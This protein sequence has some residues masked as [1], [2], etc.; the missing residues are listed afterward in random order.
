MSQEEV[1]NAIEQSEEVIDEAGEFISGCHEYQTR[2]ALV[3]PI[4]TSLGWDI[5]DVNQVEVEYDTDWGRVDYALLKNPDG[6]LAIAVEAKALWTNLAATSIQRQILSYAEGR[7]KGYLVLTD[8]ETWQIYDLG[9]RGRFQN[10]LVEHLS[11]GESSAASIAKTLNQALRRN[12]H[13]KS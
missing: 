8:G 4:L 13:W 1:Q 7:K 2:Y 12:L 6:E 3:D 9:K 10:K 5:S 11:I